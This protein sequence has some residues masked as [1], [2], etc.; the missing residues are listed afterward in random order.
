[1]ERGYENVI[2]SLFYTSVVKKNIG[3]VGNEE[4]GRKYMY[5]VKLRSFRTFDTWTL[6]KLL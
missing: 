1:M 2:S 6:L 4:E 3:S 5:N